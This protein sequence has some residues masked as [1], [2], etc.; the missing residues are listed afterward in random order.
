MQE[1]LTYYFHGVRND[2]AA[3]EH[4]YSVEVIYYAMFYRP[5]LSVLFCE[6]RDD[7]TEH[8]KWVTETRSTK[9]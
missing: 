6:K 4:C 7:I 9:D 3:Y 5:T 1:Q 8:F 2:L